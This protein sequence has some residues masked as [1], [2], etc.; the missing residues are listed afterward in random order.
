MCTASDR[1]FDAATGS[2]NPSATASTGEMSSAGI[3]AT[4]GRHWRD[5]LNGSAASTADYRAHVLHSCG[6]CRNAVEGCS[7]IHWWRPQP[8]S[9]RPGAMRRSRL[10]FKR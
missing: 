10:Q 2:Q 5:R 9:H 8:F 3:P 7:P 4:S 1:A 6:N